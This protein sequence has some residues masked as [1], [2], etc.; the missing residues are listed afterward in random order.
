MAEPKIE[1]TAPA[2]E[3]KPEPA[4]IPKKRVKREA[5]LAEL[6][7]YKAEAQEVPFE[8]EELR[9][10]HERRLEIAAK[11]LEVM[12][13]MHDN[14]DALKGEYLGRELKTFFD[15]HALSLDEEGRFEKDPAFE[16]VQL[17]FVNLGELDRI[18]QEG[19]H[20]SGD[21]ALQMLRDKIE[22]VVTSELRGLGDPATFYEVY[23]SGGSKFSIKLDKVP[24]EIAE[25]IRIKLD[26]SLD[27]SSILPGKDSAPLAA[28]RIGL[29]ELT[30]IFNQ[31]PEEDR[32]AIA[33]DP[34]SSRFMIGTAFEMLNQ[35]NDKR[36]TEA[37]L[38]RLVEMIKS[39]NEAAAKAFY[40][41]YQARALTPLFSKSADALL[42]YEEVR[43][44][45]VELGALENGAWAG[46]KAEMALKEARRQ[47]ESRRLA[48]RDTE[49][50]ISEAAAKSYIE[51]HGTTGE[52]QAKYI[53]QRE[54]V[55]EKP[56]PTEGQVELA[57]LARAKE[58][59]EAA[60]GGKE[61]PERGAIDPDCQDAERAE[62]DLELAEAERD[63]M[64]G[65]KQRGPLFRSLEAALENNESVSTV[66]IDMAFLKYFDKEGGRDTGNLAIKKAGEILDLVAAKFKEAGKRVEAYRIGGDEFAFSVAGEDEAFLREILKELDAHQVAAGEVP[67][68]GEAP[69]GVYADQA[70]LFNYGVFHAPSK[71]EMKAM[72][73]EQGLELES[74]GTAEENNELAEYMLRFADKQLEIQK[75]VNR[76][77]VLL[78]ESLHAPDLSSGKYAQLLK[79]SEKAI[80]GESGKKKL[81]EWREKLLPIMEA[82]A[83]AETPE[84][85]AA[86]EDARSRLITEIEREAIEFSIEEI[87]KKHSESENYEGS[88]DKIIE[89][90]VREKFLEQKISALETRIQELKAEIL[91]KE[92]ENDA[93]SEE[94]ERLKSRVAFLEQE[95]DQI[96]ALRK[97]IRG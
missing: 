11:R 21:L 16:D 95:K 75:A 18:N 62:L 37:R 58:E 91:A 93:L 80:F 10:A 57:R 22:E 30:D 4:F 25:K 76:L 42:T 52:T 7:G 97:E 12:D 5:L 27:I 9:S 74:E 2:A 79:Y 72:L 94:N 84:A 45:L 44:K 35:L 48:Q 26:T 89:G 41:K 69:I 65:L 17:L 31:L 64:T 46:V 8:N 14:T 71:E 38:D 40:T 90:H 55:F 47:F 68:S 86:A 63:S 82:V 56:K 66:Y 28:S 34:S 92:S 54:S 53:K 96:T 29:D 24:K 50:K 59:A 49:R 77:Q 85:K 33:L 81:A 87:R 61:C 20:H 32:R 67:L 13:A 73:A 60:L 15:E 36:E 3:R 43:A 83:K 23:R 19:D 39:G 88:I 6:E 1:I 78:Q 70:L 51:F